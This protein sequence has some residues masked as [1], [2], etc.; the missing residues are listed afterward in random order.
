MRT[1]PGPGQPANLDGIIADLQRRL[2]Q[3][4]QYIDTHRDELELGDFVRVINLQG[5]LAN[6][7]GRLM[8]DRQQLTGDDAGELSAAIDEALNVVGELLGVEL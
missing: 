1:L 5:Q 8:R 3:L 6:R 4:S 7:I 2:D